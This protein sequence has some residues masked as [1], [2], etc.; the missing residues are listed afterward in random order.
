MFK[1]T[2]LEGVQLLVMGLC[3]DRSSRWLRLGAEG[4]TGAPDLK[5]PMAG[6]GYQCGR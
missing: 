5:G 2:I 1:C 3:A 6:M 4:V